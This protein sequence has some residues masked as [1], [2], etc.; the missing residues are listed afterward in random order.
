MLLKYC[1]KMTVI[2]ILQA[3]GNIRYTQSGGRK[4]HHCP[5]DAG[6]FNVLMQGHTGGRLNHTIDGIGMKMECTAQ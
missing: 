6:I 3:M 4:E 2:I 1:G 5:F